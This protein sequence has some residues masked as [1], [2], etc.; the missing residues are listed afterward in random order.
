MIHCLHTSF[1]LSSPWLQSIWSIRSVSQNIKFS[2]K[3]YCHFSQVFMIYF[4]NGNCKTSQEPIESPNHSQFFSLYFLVL[5]GQSFIFADILFWGCPNYNY[6]YLSWCQIAKKCITCIRN[7]YLNHA[8]NN[9]VNVTRKSNH[10]HNT[11]SL[12]I[13]PV[14]LRLLNLLF[15]RPGDF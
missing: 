5:D 8:T 2:Q 6:M 3:I 14:P 10:L 7:V 15:G 4:P 13:Y 9:F 1:T 12:L 11:C